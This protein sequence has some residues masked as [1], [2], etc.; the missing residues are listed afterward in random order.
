VTIKIATRERLPD[1]KE[2][3]ELERSVGVRFPE[4]YVEFLTKYT[5]GE[6]EPNSFRLP[7]GDVSKVEWIVA[8][9]RI[10]VM[11]TALQYR[12]GPG[13]LPLALATAGELVLRVD[14]GSVLYYDYELPGPEAL[15]MVA[16]SIKEFL[17]S[18]VVV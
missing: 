4:A 16:G 18:L 15:T 3:E 5:G 2:V 7:D 14:D 9:S 6:P 11:L 13:F 1:H 8:W 17:E 12:F 10:P